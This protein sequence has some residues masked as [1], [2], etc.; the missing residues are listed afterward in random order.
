MLKKKDITDKLNDIN[1][2]LNLANWKIDEL[3]KQ[4]QQ[5]MFDNQALQ[6]ANQLDLLN[7]KVAKQP[8]FNFDIDTQFLNQGNYETNLNVMIRQ[9][10]TQ[11][12]I[13]SCFENGDFL[14]YLL[15]LQRADYFKARVKIINYS[16]SDKRLI[17]NTLYYGALNGWVAIND[18][19]ELCEI[20]EIDKNNVLTYKVIDYDNLELESENKEYKTNSFIIYEFNNNHFGLWILAYQYLTKVSQYFS[21][22]DNQTKY[23]TTQLIAK[24]NK[25][26]VNSRSDIMINE[27]WNKDTPFLQIA[28]DVELAPLN[29]PSDNL[30]TIFSFI[31]NFKNWFD[32]NILK[33]TTKDITSDKERDVASQQ[34]NY[35]NQTLINNS[36]LNDYLEE[37]LTGFNNMF[38]VNG[39]YRDLISDNL[40][41]QAKQSLTLSKMNDESEKEKNE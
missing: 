5:L 19:K 35:A 8:L 7:S 4:R 33:I 9:K 3:E 29:N 23:L 21:I 2:Q 24:V 18:K 26:D 14:T 20:I 1:K 11:P 6:N 15:V 16:Y 30:Q 38:N 27:L 40:I 31:E 13:K 36:F 37:F 39:W 10:M 41:N 28:K 22:L 12:N 34:S 17:L 25:E 32:F